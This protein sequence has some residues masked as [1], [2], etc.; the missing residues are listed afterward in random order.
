MFR[1]WY[2]SIT[3]I[4]NQR[5]FVQRFLQSMFF[6]RVNQAPMFSIC[7][8]VITRI[9]GSGF[10]LEFVG[11]VNMICWLSTCIS[12]VTQIKQGARFLSWSTGWQN[13]RPHRCHGQLKLQPLYNLY[14]ILLSLS[15]YLSLRFIFHCH[16]ITVTLYLF[17]M[18]APASTAQSSK[19][20][21]SVTK[22]VF[23]KGTVTPMS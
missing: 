12:Q 15:P 6:C 3:A 11:V 1:F 18:I 10:I 13:H 14:A 20:L 23:V 19:H 7:N 22:I 9:H 21:T 16:L 2:G 8:T 4:D 5:G 17:Q